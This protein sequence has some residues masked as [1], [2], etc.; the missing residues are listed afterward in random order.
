MLCESLALVLSPNNLYSFLSFVQRRY[1]RPGTI[2]NEGYAFFPDVLNS[3]T[4]PYTI[5]FIRI[6][7]NIMS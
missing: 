3:K 6:V 1:Q 2:L 4:I 5:F 7:D